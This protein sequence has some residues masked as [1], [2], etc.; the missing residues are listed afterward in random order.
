MNEFERLLNLIT[1]GE[2]DAVTFC[3]PNPDFG[4]NGGC[5]R[6]SAS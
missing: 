1:D 6:I 3:S 2:G 5:K 4:V